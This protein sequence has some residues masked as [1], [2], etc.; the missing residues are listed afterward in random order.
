M[1]KFVK[2]VLEDGM[3]NGNFNTYKKLYLMITF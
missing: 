1:Q 3:R 2:E